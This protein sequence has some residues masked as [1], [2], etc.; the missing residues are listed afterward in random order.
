[1]K[2]T[3]L[4]VTAIIFIVATTLPAA[5]ERLK[6]G[7]TFHHCDNCPEM[8]VVPPG[9]FWMGSNKESNEQPIHEVTINYQFAV[10]VHE[11]SFNEWKHCVQQRG[12]SKTA[13]APS[14]KNQP[15]GPVISVSWRDAKSYVRWLSKETGEEYRLLT[16]AEWEYAAQNEFDLGLYDMVG[17]VWEWVED[18]WHDNYEGAPTDGS[19]WI[20]RGNCDYRVARGG[21]WFGKPD[22][23]RSAGRSRLGTV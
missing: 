17:S 8:V 4:I 15:D 11:V 23:L 12:C 9:F 6:P 22:D 2:K 10:G 13:G 3:I 14:D 1:M 7:D 21:S 20:A 19:A 5:A 16:E 18:C